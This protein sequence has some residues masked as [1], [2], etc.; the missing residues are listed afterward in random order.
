MGDVIDDADK[1]ANVY[2]NAALSHIKIPTAT[3]VTDCIDCGDPI[4]VERKQAAPYATRCRECQFY[5]D[6]EQR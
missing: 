1:T 4:G 3:A 2:L 5:Y 6:K